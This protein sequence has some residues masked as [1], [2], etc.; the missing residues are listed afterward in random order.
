MVHVI[1]PRGFDDPSDAFASDP[2][3]GFRT[4]C[5]FLH[6]TLA[7]PEGSWSD[8]VT[9]AHTMPESLRWMVDWEEKS[10]HE[11]AHPRPE[12]FPRFTLNASVS[13]T[14][15]DPAPLLSVSVRRLPQAD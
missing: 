4:G 10:K 15:R 6:L 5:G 14:S 3:V 8:A 1:V 7:T 11:E 12:D 2:R 13:K 9:L